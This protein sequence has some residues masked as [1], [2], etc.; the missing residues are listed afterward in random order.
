MLHE[1]L[2]PAA[3]VAGVVTFFSPCAV[4][5]LPTYISYYIGRPEE[6]LGVEGES[7]RVGLVRS[8]FLAIL[9][10]ALVTLG[11]VRPY[12]EVVGATL[13]HGP[14]D[15]TLIVLGTVILVLFAHRAAV[16]FRSVSED[17]VEGLRSGVK[18]GLG[19]GLATTAGFFTLF[20]LVGGAVLLGASAFV[21]YLPH[22][23]FA[24]AALIVVMGALSLANVN[25]SVIPKFLAP[26]GRGLLSFFAFGLGFAAISAGCLLPVFGAVLVNV[27][28]AVTSGD[29]LMA[30]SVLLV[31]AGGMGTMM[32]V[33]TA[34]VAVA[35]Q[36]S[37]RYLHRTMPTVKRATGAIVIAM[38]LFV[39]WYSWTFFLAVA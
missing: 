6:D 17:E 1:V 19:F 23:A 5:L 33:F 7:S 11:F 27:I 32:I 36:A 13:V 2:I 25:V 28:A 15:V 9:G 8:L 14:I 3:F 22:V 37:Q 16:K 4:A 39:L 18:R 29:V 12:L 35:K 26:R 34:H 31:Y 24:T 10:G 20:L 30:S 21:A 38:G